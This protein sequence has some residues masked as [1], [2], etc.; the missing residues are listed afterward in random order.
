[1]KIT[2]FKCSLINLGLFVKSL[3]SGTKR[4]C[5]WITHCFF[6]P[7]LWSTFNAD[8]GIN[9]RGK[10]WKIDLSRNNIVCSSFFFRCLRFFG[11]WCWLELLLFNLMNYCPINFGWQ[12][13]QRMTKTCIDN[14]GFES[15]HLSFNCTFLRYIILQMQVESLNFE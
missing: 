12:H 3:S 14:F 4:F 8:F 11:G 6:L 1:M 9:F 13:H 15:H 7:K 2:R 10:F 5:C